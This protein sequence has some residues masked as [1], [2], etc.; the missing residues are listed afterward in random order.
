[1]PVRIT[2]LAVMLAAAGAIAA[3]APPSSAGGPPVLD[4]KKKTSLSFS[5]SGGVQDNDKDFVGTTKDRADCAAPRCAAMPF[6]YKPAKG[7]QGDT[8]YLLTWT[9]PAS[10]FDLYVAE[11]GKAG[12]R[13]T[14]AKCG[15]GAGRSEKVFIPA[16]TLKSGH[17]YAIVVDFYRS[18]NEKFTA[19]VTLP[20]ANAV[21]SKVPTTAEKVEPIN[22]GL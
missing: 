10:D 11:V 16:G 19:T 17:V 9:N 15:A 14:V 20:G 7:V 8:A 4:G 18:L 1:M 2:A 22:C 3:T 12:G 13:S 5:G 21:G 6:V